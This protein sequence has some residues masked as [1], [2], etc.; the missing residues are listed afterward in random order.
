M[1]RQ[2]DG[3]IQLKNTGDNLIDKWEQQLADGDEPDLLEAF[4]PEAVE[5][6]R[7]LHKRK[8]K[9]APVS[10]GDTMRHVNELSRKEGWDGPPRSDGFKTFGDE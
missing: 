1:H 5:K 4:T 7:G 8:R 2:A 6:I 10:F 9:R 3:E